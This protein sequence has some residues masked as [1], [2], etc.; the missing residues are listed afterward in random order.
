MRARGPDP[1]T[2]HGRPRDDPGNLRDLDSGGLVER[3]PDLLTPGEDRV[4]EML[5]QEADRL[6]IGDGAPDRK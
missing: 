4:I 1:L 6:T 3:L 2:A 5:D